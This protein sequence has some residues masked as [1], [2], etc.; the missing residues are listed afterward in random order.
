MLLILGH[1][2]QHPF[3][4]TEDRLGLF[5]RWWNQLRYRLLV[6]RDDHFLALSELVNQFWE[7]RLRFLDCHGAHNCS[8]SL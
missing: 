5:S 7:L 1:N 3:A 4:T 2:G 6:M 8:P